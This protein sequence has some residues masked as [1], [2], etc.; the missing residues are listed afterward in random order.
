MTSMD[1]L[2]KVFAPD[3]RIYQIEYAFKAIQAAGQNAIA[4]RGND[5]VVVCTQ[6]KVPDKLIVPDSVTN[7]YTIANGI[8]AVI[9]G[10][11]NDAR[12]MVTQIRATAAEFQMKFS[13]ECPIQV[14]AQRMG[15]R[16]QR[17][18]QYAGIRPFCCMIT[19]V[20][21]DEE[22]GP[23][24]YKIDPSGSAIG[25]K[26]LAT[27]SKEQEATTQLE[28]A[29]KK[30]NGDW[31]TKQSVEV[32]VKT[33]STV[34]S[35]DFRANEIEVGIATVDQPLFRKLSEQEIDQVLNEMAD[36]M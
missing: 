3:G 20:G 32:A 4:I 8:G 12:V 34:V 29:F 24:V 27:G 30:N 14:L 5:C 13:Y 36:A 16:L 25:Y 28:R 11:S 19:L 33:L 10:N 2:M 22:Y 7:I 23:Q 6:K 15:A 21:C 18:S 26:A 35:S 9:V 17:F 31:N 1:K